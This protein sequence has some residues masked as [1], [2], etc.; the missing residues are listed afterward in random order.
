MKIRYRIVAT[1]VLS[2]ALGS[3]VIVGVDGSSKRFLLDKKGGA[4]E[5]RTAHADDQQTRDAVRRELRNEARS[6][7]P[8][9]T[10]AMQQHKKQIKYQYEKTAQGG[11][12][13]IVAKSPEALLAVQD[14]LRS[15]MRNS[16]NNRGVAFDFIG[17]TSLVVLPV[18]INNGGPYK[19]LLDTGAS[20]T[21]LS[22]LVADNLGIP[23]GRDETLLTA[24][25]NLTVTLRTIDALQVGAVRLE[26][27]EIAVANFGL[28][29]TLN[30][31]GILGGDYLRRFKVSIDYDNHIVEIEPCCPEVMSMLV[32]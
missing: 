31:D 12:I 10:A 11:R 19:F 23:S 28:M 17:N 2:F 1:T 20:N 25:G 22:A 9:A 16:L 3:T 4:I 13:R 32:A 27:I 6:G 24:G 7:V 5:V 29:K 15:Q 18:T 26:K 14:Y 30:V 21:I 8:F